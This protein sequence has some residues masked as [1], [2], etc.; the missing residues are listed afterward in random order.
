MAALKV[1]PLIV[2]LSTIWFH[3]SVARAN[4]TTK[5]NIVMQLTEIR[6]LDNNDIIFSIYCYTIVLLCLIILATLIRGVKN[7]FPDNFKKIYRVMF[8][9]FQVE[10]TESY[11]VGTTMYNASLLGSFVVYPMKS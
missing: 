9:R 4:E 3:S 1:F 7:K 2:F 11:Y 10:F 6:I 8:S 5:L